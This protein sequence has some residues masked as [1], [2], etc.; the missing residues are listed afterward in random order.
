M[1]GTQ[2]VAVLAA[3]DSRARSHGIIG[4]SAFDRDDVRRSRTTALIAITFWARDG[5]RIQGTAGLFSR[6]VLRPAAGAAL[7]AFIAWRYAERPCVRLPGDG[8]FRYHRG[9]PAAWRV[10]NAVVAGYDQFAGISDVNLLYYRAAGVVAR[11]SGKTI[12]V[13]Q[14][15]MR[16]ELN[17]DAP[18]I[19]AG[20]FARGQERAARYYEMRRRGS[21]IILSDPKAVALDWVAGAARTVFGRET[22]EWAALLGLET[23][24]RPWL[25]VRV[26]L[27][28]IWFP[29]LLLALVG[30][31]R[32]RWDLPLVLP[33]LLVSTYLVVLGAGPEAY[34]RFRVPFVPVICVFAAA[35]AI[36]VRQR[37]VIWLDGRSH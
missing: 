28:A 35:G 4:V 24:S 16:R 2:R 27:T 6:R 32:V 15:Q 13:V 25:I 10:R 20:R 8:L 9:P 34:S 37:M 14:L 18:L 21:A 12:D 3:T 1:R 22:A 36:H 30:L 26:L 31:L 7:M 11:R 23:L 17:V 29:L 19:S 5:K 33:G